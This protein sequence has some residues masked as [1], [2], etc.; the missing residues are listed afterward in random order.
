M[1]G[2]TVPQQSDVLV[3]F[4]ITGDLA[5]V[6][7]FGSLYR[8]EKR[9]LL[10]CPVVG[11]AV[12]DW[13]MD[14]LRENARRDIAGTGV[15]VS[16]DVFERL[17]A[18]F[19]YVQGDFLTDDTY[20]RL[21]EEIGYA[22]DPAF[23]LE[24]PPSLFGRV[25]G[26]LAKA[27][28]T[29]NA[30]VIVEKP[31]G[32]DLDSAKALND[33]LHQHITEEQLYRID[34][35]LGKMSVE[36]I[37]YLRFGNQI[38][39][40]V[41]NSK[42]ISSVQITM[43]ENFGVA[44]RGSF[45][46]PVGT[47][48]DVVQNHLLQVLSMVAM[49]PPAG[50]GTDVVNSRKRDVFAAMPPADPK[51]YV[52]GQYEGY[53]QVPGVAAK[54]TTETYCA[55]RLQIDNWRW[56]G[57]PFFIRAGK[58]LPE[59]VTEVRVVFH[60]PPPLPLTASRNE[61]PRSNEM[62]IRIDPSPGASLQLVAK[63]AKSHNYR[64]IHLDMDFADEGGEG[65]TP[66]EEL[67]S[68]AMAGDKDNFADQSAV[69]ETWRIVQPLLDDPP[70]VIPYAEGTWGPAEADALTRGYGGWHLPWLD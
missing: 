22:E 46:D 8:L 15:A 13:S 55:M 25:V 62:V 18:R 1:E 23:Y 11:V 33:E 14:D 57:V 16:D 19:S 21:A 48:R 37:L 17:M 2:A 45:Y 56:H 67:L 52:R 29:A 28:L 35:F 49:E 34:H 69:E 42:F 40:P 7:T 31:F 4:G 51:H 5:K 6:M 30:R 27:G 63:A 24:I 60:R 50:V 58:S 38:L 10:Q 3:I 59:R 61:H 47:L 65:P 43:A 64:N 12:S 66:Y 68:A 20:Q 32:H 26:H 53:L 54:S 44:D 36:D 9:G 39:E 70:P 41:W